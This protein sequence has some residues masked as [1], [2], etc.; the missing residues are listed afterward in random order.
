MIVILT[1]YNNSINL[2]L[3]LGCRD[4]MKDQIFNKRFGRRCPPSAVIYFKSIKDIE[5]TEFSYTNNFLLFKGKLK[6]YEE[7]GSV[8]L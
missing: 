4:E 1:L 8:N 3:G 7:K 2:G 5:N 6:N